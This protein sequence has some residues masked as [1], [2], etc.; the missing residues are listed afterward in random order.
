MARPELNGGYIFDIQGFSLHDGPGC[1]TLIFLKGC[2]LKCEWCSNPEG[3]NPYPEPLYDHT[4]CILDDLCL[5]ACPSGAIHKENSHM[6]FSRDLC[7]KC[8][9]HECVKACCTGAL[10]TG[11]YFI[12][13]SELLRK[14]QRDRQYWG[15]NGGITLTGGEPFSQPAFTESV[16]KSCYQSLIHT[17]VETC[18][19]V[20]WKNIESSL[21]YLDWIFYDVKHVD[22][23][24]HKKHTGYGNSKILENA[25]KLSKA[26]RGRLIFRM[27]VVPGFNDNE[28]HL[29]KLAAFIRTTGRDEINILPLHHLGREKHR[30]T[31]MKYYTEDF[32]VP[33]RK[34]L[35]GI[36][37]RLNSLGLR[38]YT[39]SDTP[40]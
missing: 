6:V 27:S 1:R 32:K 18:G 30:L 26:F 37:D 12:G 15:N 40:F 19:N 24:R 39:A 28:E 25:L 7:S 13:I 4:K 3:L 31:G 35:L 16:L 5:K 34:E 14:I 29:E 9:S 23:D 17:A 36:R 8:T 21:P 11:G 20:P 22:P 33:A 38:C 2:S 10:R